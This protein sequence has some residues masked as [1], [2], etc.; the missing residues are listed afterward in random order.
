MNKVDER[1]NVLFVSWRLSQGYSMYPN[2]NKKNE[3]KE[4]RYGVCVSND[5]RSEREQKLFALT[6]GCKLQTLRLGLVCLN[7]FYWPY[8]ARRFNYIYNSFTDF[9]RLFFFFFF[10]LQ[11]FIC[12]SKQIV[13]SFL[14]IREKKIDQIFFEIFHVRFDKREK[15][16]SLLARL[17]NLPYEA[18]NA[19]AFK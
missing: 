10:F 15:K 12:D 5:P 17:N 1:R 3:F 4:C 2:I 13:D 16:K 14:I 8:L 9:L 18:N 11:D 19:I 7:T 6:R